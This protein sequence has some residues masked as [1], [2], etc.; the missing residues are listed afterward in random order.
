MAAQIMQCLGVGTRR[1][2]G[3]RGGPNPSGV[4]EEETVEGGKKER[5]RKS[6]TAS[7]ISAI[8]REGTIAASHCN[9][10]LHYKCDRI[11]GS[12]TYT[13]CPAN[14]PYNKTN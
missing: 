9:Y 3:K 12:D 10:S 1:G 4:W 7:Q 11:S 6:G 2:R 8:F 13:T 5:K 14:L